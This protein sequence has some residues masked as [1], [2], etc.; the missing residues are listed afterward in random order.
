MI[1]R[2]PRSTLSSS[3]A[4]SDVYKRQVSTQ[5]TGK[6]VIYSWCA[7]SQQAEP[8]PRAKDAA[9]N[10]GSHHPIRASSRDQ[11]ALSLQPRV[12]QHS[13]RTPAKPSARGFSRIQEST[14]PRSPSECHCPTHTLTVV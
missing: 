5:S 9:N 1:R 6:A 7:C 12:T 4:A 10:R 8:T 2:P 13:F 14:S 3:S 11:G